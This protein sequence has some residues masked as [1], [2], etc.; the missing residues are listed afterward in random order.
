MP[1]S[2]IFQLNYVGQFCCWRNLEYPEKTTDLSQVTDNLYHMMPPIIITK[3]YPNCNVLLINLLFIYEQLIMGILPDRLFQH[4]FLVSF[5]LF[6]VSK[7][8]ILQIDIQA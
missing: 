1:L 7:P 3:Y 5:G 4:Y 2:T 8:D 6:S